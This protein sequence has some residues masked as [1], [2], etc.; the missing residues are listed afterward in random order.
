MTPK[1][2][3]FQVKFTDTA[4]EDLRYFRKFDQA[5]VIDGITEQLEHE[6]LR[7]TRSKK[8]L[9]PNEVSRWELRIDRF[10]VFYDADAENQVVLIKAVGWKEHNTLIIRGREFHL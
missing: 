6:P 8:P 10:R 5:I 2:M 1:A 3:S 7:Q 4:L 9:R